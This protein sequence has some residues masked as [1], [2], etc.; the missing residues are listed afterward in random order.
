MS[1]PAARA[2]SWFLPPVNTATRTVLPMP[3]GSTV[4]P[5]TCWS[6]LLA[7]M[8]RLTATSTD[9]A[10]FAVANSFTSSRAS[11][12]GYCLP[13]VSL[14]FQA[15]HALGYGWHVRCPPRRR[16]CCG[17]CR[18]WCA[19]RLRGRRRS[20]RASS[21][22]QL[23]RAAC[24]VILP[25]LAV[26]GVPLPFSM[27]IALRISTDAG[28]VFMMKVKLRSEYT[29][30]ITGIGS[31]F[32][33]FWVCALNCLQNSMMFTPCW[34]SAGPIGRRRIGRSRWHLQLD[35]ALYFLCHSHRT[36]WVQ[37]PLEAPQ[38]A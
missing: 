29:V 10:N 27:P 35:V 21:S 13:G 6:D 20:G 26:F 31:P 12:I 7:S 22:S 24:G 17:R 14:P 1:A 25:T 30:M 5:R 23:L 37:T 32:S 34:P 4:E 38:S 9:S 11:S 8:P 36:P 18:R 33:S 19:P 2:A 28:G 3:C 15:L 16:P